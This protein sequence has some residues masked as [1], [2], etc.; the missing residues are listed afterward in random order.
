MRLVCLLVLL[1]EPMRPLLAKE[2]DSL[3][4]VLINFFLFAITYAI[5][6]KIAKKNRFLSDFM[7]KFLWSFA[8]HLGAL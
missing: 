4:T 7:V 5:A 2:S 6:Y 3:E 8:P 1:P